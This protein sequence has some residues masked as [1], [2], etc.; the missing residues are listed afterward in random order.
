MGWNLTIGL[1][2]LLWSL[3]IGEEPKAP[4]A[5]L[6]KPQTEVVRPPAPAYTAG[7][8]RAPRLPERAATQIDLEVFRAAFRRQA[9]RTLIQCLQDWQPPPGK[10]GLTALLDRSG[11]LLHTA[12]LSPT[13]TLPDCATQAI[14]SMRFPELGRRLDRSS[15]PLQWLVEW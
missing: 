11:R 9:Q 10:L 2:V 3:V 8:M 15:L 1:V 6:L 13:I 5:P 14:A 7:R 4:P 12:T